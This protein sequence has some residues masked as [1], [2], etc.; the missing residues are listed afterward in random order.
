MDQPDQAAA[1]ILFPEERVTRLLGHI[2]VSL[3]LAEGQPLS[4]AEW[5][6]LTHHPPNTIASWSAGGAAHQ[7]QVLLA[8][9]ERLPEVERHRLID[10]ACREFPTLH[11]S[12]LAHDFVAGSRLATLLRQPCGLTFIQGA[13]E[14]MRTYLLSALGHSAGSKAKVAGLDIHRPDTFV[15]VIGVSY[16]PN[17][18]RIADIKKGFER[19]WPGIVRARAH[20]ILLNGVW[21][22]AR[23][24]QPEILDTARHSHVV[25][26]DSF[27]LQPQDLANKVSAPTHLVNVSPAREQVAWV[28]VEIQ[29]V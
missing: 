16:L 4:Y 3:G 20:L 5:G 22:A 21:R 8:S 19:L 29:A 27:Q 12:K 17:L 25:V 24:L 18:L 9:L 26:A 15:P 10:A 28:R 14:H 13:P 6:R 11:H 2:K 23:E 7:L 1:S